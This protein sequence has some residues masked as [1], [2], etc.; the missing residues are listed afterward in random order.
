MLDNPILKDLINLENLSEGQ[1][2][3]A[4][5][6]VL[7]QL[8]KYL[9]ADQFAL[10]QKV[11]PNCD[12][13]IAAAPEVKA[14]LLGGLANTLG[15]EKAKALLDLNKGLGK[16]GLSTEKQKSMAATLKDSVEKH[17]PELASL[18]DLA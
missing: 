9:Q 17:Y 4:L 7:A 11:I 6:L 8:R 14:G 3:G 15:G 18:I 2:A 1:A 13:L 10:L 16:L 5:G 12:E